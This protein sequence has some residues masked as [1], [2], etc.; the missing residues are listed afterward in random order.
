MK[1]SVIAA[2]LAATVAAP[3]VAEGDAEAG[4]TAFDRQCV[5]C[6]VVANAAG[7]VLA[8]R[9]ARTGPNLFGVATGAVGSVEGFR[10][11]DSI[12]AVNATGAVW[13]EEDFVAYVQ[14][15]TEWLR[16]KLDDRRARSKM[17][18]RVRSVE[19]AENIYA[20]LATFTE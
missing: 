1:T 7:D 15:P 12:L 13:S 10:Y 6:H 8:G 4:A 16:T 18:F 5:S 9:N 3:A 20:Y 11:G 19:D 17:S 2:L 14:D